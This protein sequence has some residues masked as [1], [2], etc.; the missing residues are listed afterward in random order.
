MIKHST[1][2]LCNCYLQFHEISKEYWIL[3]SYLYYI[4][5][6]IVFQSRGHYTD[7]IIIGEILRGKIQSKIFTQR[8][9]WRKYKNAC[10][11][12]WVM[13]FIFKFVFLCVAL[14]LILLPSL[15]PLWPLIHAIVWPISK[16]ESISSRISFLH[17]ALIGHFRWS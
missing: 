12:L 10:E 7:A 6:M 15:S 5:Y 13:D 3:M 8:L 11:V 16:H 17:L 2:L 1:I 14:A 4:Y 9:K